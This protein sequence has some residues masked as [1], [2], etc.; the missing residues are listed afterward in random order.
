MRKGSRETWLVALRDATT[1]KLPQL[2]ALF[3]GSPQLRLTATIFGDRPW[4]TPLDVHDAVAQLVDE[5]VDVIF[6]RQR[7]SASPQ[8]QVRAF[9]TVVAAKRESADP[10]VT[11][12]IELHER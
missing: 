2:R 10:R 3:A 4:I 12:R 8:W 6:P 5:I 7:G 1:P 9:W 11:I